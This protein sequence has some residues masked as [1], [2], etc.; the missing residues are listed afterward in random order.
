MPFP[1][2]PHKPISGTLKLS[3]RSPEVTTTVGDS[4]PKDEF[5][6]QQ[7]HASG[8]KF[9]LP[10][11]L[12]ITKNPSDVVEGQRNFALSKIQGLRDKGRK[13]AACREATTDAM[14]D[15]AS[16]I[17]NSVCDAYFNSGGY[18]HTKFSHEKD[19]SILIHFET[20]LG[21][22]DKMLG[23]SILSSAVETGHYLK[24]DLSGEKNFRLSGFDV[25]PHVE[26][27]LT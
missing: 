26:W 7:D 5:K 8:F 16:S 10:P 2:V 13:C 27:L 17:V 21:N 20:R 19:G 24:N 14:L 12:S 4:D 25:Q 22:T 6:G 11:G 1:K 9:N 23:V 18:H 15:I 3:V